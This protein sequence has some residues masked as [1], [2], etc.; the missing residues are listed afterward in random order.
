MNLN[1]NSVIQIL[2][3]QVE[4]VSNFKIL[5]KSPNVFNTSQI[6]TVKSVIHS[7]FFKN[8]KNAFLLY[9]QAA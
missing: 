6:K 1:A 3:Q 2:I 8:P 5:K 7:I 9:Q 4:L